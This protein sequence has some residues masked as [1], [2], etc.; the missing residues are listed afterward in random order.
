MT[1]P[2]GA[3]RVRATVLALAVA[4]CGPYA[5]VAQKL[6]VTARVAGDTWIAAAGADR[7]ELRVLLVGQPRE[8]GTAAF[9]FTALEMPISRG[10]AATTLQGSWT[11]VGSAGATTLQ[12]AH[13]YTLLDETGNPLNRRGS[14]RDD[15]ARTLRVTVT[16]QAG[17]LAVAGDPALAGT[18]VPVREAL[19]R[20]ATAPEAAACAFQV[21]NLAIRSSEVRIIGFGGATML[22]YRST[23][24]YVGT[25]AGDL[26]VHLSGDLSGSTTTIDYRAF[27][28]FGGVRVG[29]PQITDVN[30][31][32]SGHMSGVMTFELAPLAADGTAAPAI[33]GTIDYGDPA[34]PVQISNGTATGGSYLARIDGGGSARIA[35]EAPPSPSVSDCLD[36]P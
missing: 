11:E 16:R 32:A 34:D 24:T 1:G 20:L 6:D 27:E 9:A 35:P 28:D 14:F 17:T 7:S 10:A 26:S 3:G 36:L 15:T 29:G 12:V 23:A 30:S 31:S 5:E 33:T 2:G 22:Q 8:D 13:T 18:Y 4:A 21:A 19:A 25:V